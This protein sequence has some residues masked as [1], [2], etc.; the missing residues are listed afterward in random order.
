KYEGVPTVDVRVGY[1]V[2]VIDKK[3]NRRVEQGPKTLLLEYDETLELLQLSTG[4]PKG[5]DRRV[6]ETVFLRVAN[7]QVGDLC[8]VETADHVKARLSLV[9]RVSFRG[10][11]QRWFELDNYVQRICDQA[12]SLLKAA[13][14][15]HTVE[16][17]H[18]SAPEIVKDILLGQPD[19]AGQRPGL[20]FSENGMHVTD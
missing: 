2:M 1:A 13:V 11:P 3:G 9:L 17:L 4:H 18:A 19:E 8:D 12:R 15:R 20:F 14:K 16:A 7:N 10:E 6:L 5:T